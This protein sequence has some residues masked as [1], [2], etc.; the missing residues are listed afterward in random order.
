MNNNNAMRTLSKWQYGTLVWLNDNRVTEDDLRGIRANTIWSLLHAT[1]HH[2]QP[3]AAHV[4]ESNG[5][6]RIALTRRGIEAMNTYRRPEP[7]ARAKERDLTERVARLLAT[8][9]VI[10]ARAARAAKAA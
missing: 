5:H 9:R 7:A 2:P 8:V 1:P 6:V 3:L 4:R 10:R